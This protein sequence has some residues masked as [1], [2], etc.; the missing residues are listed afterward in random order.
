ME[1][2][3]NMVDNDFSTENIYQE[4]SIFYLS[5]LFNYLFNFQI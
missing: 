4:I 5:L 3:A 1:K 2:I